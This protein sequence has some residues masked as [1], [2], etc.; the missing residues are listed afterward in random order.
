LETAVA[1]Q[2]DYVVTNDDAI[3]ALKSY[4]GIEIVSAVRFATILAY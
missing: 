4:Q 2:A 3:L 1:G